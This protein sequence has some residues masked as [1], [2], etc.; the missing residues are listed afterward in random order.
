MTINEI[1]IKR[2]LEPIKDDF[3]DMK[4]IGKWNSE[5][6]NYTSTVTETPNFKS[7]NLSFNINDWIQQGKKQQELANKANGYLEKE[8]NIEVKTDRNQIAVM[9]LADVHFG[10]YGANYNEIER[11][12][13]VILNTDGL[14]VVLGGDICEMAIKMRGMKEVSGNMF[15]PEQQ[16]DFLDQW[17]SQ[18]Q[19]KVL[20]AIW[21]NHEAE[22][23]ENAGSSEYGRIIRKYTNYVDGIAHVN[24]KVGSEVYKIAASHR[25]RGGVSNQNPTAS[26]IRYLEGAGKGME[27]GLQGDT[28]LSGV[29]SY[30]TSGGEQ[31]LALNC[32]TLHTDSHFSKRYFSILTD[33]K[34]PVFTLH[35]NKHSF[36][37]FNSV[38]D[39]KDAISF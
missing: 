6:V 25:F 17:L 33:Q 26:T 7:Q 5:A 27:I 30:T 22:R 10:S 11:L 14:Y 37:G 18:I 38:D 32:G 34:M 20:F 19:H 13:N 24:L 16:M 35:K 8:L 4:F 12:T 23:L 3:A 9:L 31:R 15:T 21:G 2:G 39:W 36:H 28:H 1:R 29:S